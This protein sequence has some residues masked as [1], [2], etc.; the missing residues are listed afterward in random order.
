MAHLLPYAWISR[1]CSISNDCSNFSIIN[2]CGNPQPIA[3]SHM[4]LVKLFLILLPIC[5]AFLT[6]IPFFD[7]LALSEVLE[8]CSLECSCLHAENWSFHGMPRKRWLFGL[9]LQKG[10]F[11]LAWNLWFQDHKIAAWVTLKVY[12]SFNS[13]SEK[14]M[15]LENPHRLLT[16]TGVQG[17]MW[18]L[19][20]LVD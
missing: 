3:L 12:A 10:G 15:Q 9:V 16:F 17:K 11:S 2:F 4:Y 18:G 5:P 8:I 19:D 20:V 14:N 1:L 13:S 6:H 7:V